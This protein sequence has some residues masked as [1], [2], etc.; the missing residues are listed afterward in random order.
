DGRAVR[1]HTLDDLTL[2]R[3]AR[4]D[5]NTSRTR[6]PGR[7]LANVEAHARLACVPVGTVAAEARIRHDRP[8]V[9]V[10]RGAIGL[11]GRQRPNRR[12]A[13]SDEAQNLTHHGDTHTMRH[14][15]RSSGDRMRKVDLFIA[16]PRPPVVYQNNED[17]KD[18]VDERR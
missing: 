8:D 2:V 1:E 18:P 9:A 12:G 13:T 7:F 10:E 16:R 15:T 3:I 5:R 14:A 11:G 6:W 17:E 4:N